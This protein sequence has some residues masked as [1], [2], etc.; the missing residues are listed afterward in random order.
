MDVPRSPAPHT[1]PGQPLSGHHFSMGWLPGVAE[2]LRS[3]AKQ[4]AMPQGRRTQPLPV[5]CVQLSSGPAEP[6]PQ[7]RWMSQSL[8][9][10][11]WVACPSPQRLFCGR[12]SVAIGPWKALST[13]VPPDTRLWRRFVPLPSLEPKLLSHR[14]GAPSG[15]P[16]GVGAPWL[17]RAA[18]GGKHAGP[19]PAGVTGAHPTPGSRAP[20]VPAQAFP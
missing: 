11:S 20:M 5:P 18:C 16:G 2:P 1:G 6:L 8:L 12:P 3:L 7:L 19:P 15:C 17:L 9:P 13:G 4:P 10:F 14:S